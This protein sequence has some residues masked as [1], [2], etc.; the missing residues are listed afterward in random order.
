MFPMSK[1]WMMVAQIGQ[2]VLFSIALTGAVRIVFWLFGMTLSE[3]A[4]G[5]LFVISSLLTG[6]LCAY[7]YSRNLKYAEPSASAPAPL[8]ELEETA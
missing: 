3:S 2:G 4:A 8:G 6:A 5:N 7:L 1:G